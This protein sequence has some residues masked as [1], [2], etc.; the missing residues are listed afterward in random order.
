MARQKNTFSG[1]KEKDGR[2][3]G[4]INGKAVCS[5]FDRAKVEAKLGYAVE[6]VNTPV[7]EKIVFGINERFEFIEKFV[8]MVARG[9]SNSLIIT[10]P[11][12]LGKTHTVLNTLDSMGKKEMSIGDL[13]GDFV[14]I[15]GFS[16]AKAMYR[17]LYEN[18]GKLII[19]DDCDS[20]LKDP[21]ASNILKAALDSYDRRIISWG[22]EFK[23]EDDL[24]NRFEFI[25]RVIFISN[26]TM[27]RVPQA[28]VS[29]S[30]KCDVSMTV[31]EKV[32]RIESVV[33]SNE[34]MPNYSYEV[35]AD[36]VA[37]IRKNANK[38]GDLNIR[39]AINI[40]KVR[41]HDDDGSWE[42]LALYMAVA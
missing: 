38:F 4:Y 36:V 41:Y 27:D 33:F 31:S 42:K 21:I 37:F 35:K 15:K 13:D 30:L 14:V 25:G 40:A 2:F 7:E 34:F 6:N 8:K 24:P 17:E 29:R 32:D 12:G 9:I 20:V 22:A 19:F 10:G 26:M 28:I 11:G 18:N 5:S 39:S 23:G 1:I 3:F 16:T